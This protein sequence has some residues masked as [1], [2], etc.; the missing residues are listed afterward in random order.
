VDAS[1]KAQYALKKRVVMPARPYLRPAALDHLGEI[2][3]A[4]A[5]YLSAALERVANG[6][7]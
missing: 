1:G 7:T 2:R 5:A 4:I 6:S 3:D